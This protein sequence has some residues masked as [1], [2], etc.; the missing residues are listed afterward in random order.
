MKNVITSVM[1]DSIAEEVG[2]EENDIL[3]S[4]N[5]EKIVD[6]IDYRFLTNDEEAKKLKD[7]AYQESLAEG[8]AQGILTYLDTNSKK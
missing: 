6:I 1:P 2:I 7:E 5:G 4:V 3:L 8:I